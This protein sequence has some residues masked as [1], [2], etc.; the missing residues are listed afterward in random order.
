MQPGEEKIYDVLRRYWGFDEFRPVQ[1]E[2][3][4][5]VQIGRAHVRTPVTH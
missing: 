1:A 3:I 2:I 5:S 4:R